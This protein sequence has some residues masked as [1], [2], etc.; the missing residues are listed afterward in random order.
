MKKGEQHFSVELSLVF[1]SIALIL[2]LCCAILSN[3]LALK[4]LW[5]VCVIVWGVR[6]IMDIRERIRNKKESERSVRGDGSD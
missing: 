2:S 1:N 3:G 4:I 5:A 6:I